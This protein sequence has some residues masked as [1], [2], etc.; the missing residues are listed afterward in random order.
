MLHTHDAD[1]N[2][3]DSGRSDMFGDWVSV[4]ELVLV[5]ILLLAIGRWY[6]RS[7]ER[8]AIA[9]DWIRSTSVKG[10]RL[11]RRLD[12]GGGLPPTNGS[13]RVGGGYTNLDGN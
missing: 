2:A 12:D 3:A 5:A 9:D 4:L 6:W 1:G 8:N 13:N 7:R 10:Q 11:N